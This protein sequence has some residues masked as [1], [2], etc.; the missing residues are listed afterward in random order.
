MCVVSQVIELREWSNQINY[1]FSQGNTD[2]MPMVPKS[3]KSLS[4]VCIG[5]Y[6]NLTCQVVSACVIREDE[7]MLLRVWDGTKVQMYVMSKEI[8]CFRIWVRYDCFFL[9]R[10]LL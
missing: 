10:F 2:E 7:A 6:C 3:T 9:D 4:D 5:G 1:E 8:L